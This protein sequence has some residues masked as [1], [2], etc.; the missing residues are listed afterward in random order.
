MTAAVYHLNN[1]LLVELR[2][3]RNAADNSYVNTAT[4]AVS[5]KDAAGTNL[6]GA[7]WPVSLGYV[8][9][10]NGLYQ[11]VVASTLGV[12]VGDVVTVYITATATG[13]DGEWVNH[14][15]VKQRYG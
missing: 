13:L 8:A 12:S 3:L 7:T 11:G 14:L 15:E 10:S 6:A 4:V 1:S 9:G 5:I 2:D